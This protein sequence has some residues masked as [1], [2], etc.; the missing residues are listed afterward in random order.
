MQLFF[1]SNLQDSTIELPEDESKHCIRV[2]RKQLGDILTL[3]DGKGNEAQCEITNANPKKC[4]LKTVQIK[5][6]PKPNSRHLHLVVAPT[7]NFDR[8]DWMLE[9]CTEIGIDEITFIEAENSERDK[10]NKERSEKILVQSIKQSKQYWLPQLNNIISLKELLSKETVQTTKFIAWCKTETTQGLAKHLLQSKDY[11]IMVL[12][13]PEGDFTDNELAQC[14]AKG[15]IPVSLG[16]TI[17][18]TET[19]AMYACS[20]I[21]SQIDNA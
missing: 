18:R 6:H 2:L 8:M 21:N 7:K 14:E 1:H 3:I 17:L 10:I 19:A 12:I 15:F 4:I 16:N 20:V 13:G 5:H 11:S 9:K